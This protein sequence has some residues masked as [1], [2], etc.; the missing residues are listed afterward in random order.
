MN[1]VGEKQLWNK[2]SSRWRD[3]LFHINIS[4][5]CLFAI[6]PDTMSQLY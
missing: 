2:H 3:K 4:D 6:T 1:K 5:M